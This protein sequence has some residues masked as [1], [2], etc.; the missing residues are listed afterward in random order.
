M[1]YSLCEGQTKAGPYGYSPLPLNLV[2][3]GFEQLA[4]LQGR[5]PR[6]RPRPNRDVTHVQQ[7][8]LRRREPQAATSSPRSRRSR[9]PATSRARARAA[10]TTGT[11]EPSTDDADAPTTARP[12][13]RQERRQDGGRADAAAEPGGTATAATAIDPVTGEAVTRLR[14]PAVEGVSDTAPATS[15]STPTPTELS[16]EPADATAKASAGSRSLEL[17]ALILVPGILLSRGARRR[18]RSG[19]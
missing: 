3:A 2:Q 13:R 4:K 9:P 19:R 8:D 5:R 10:P 16:A 1:Y 6:G 12:R 14:A 17:L 11:G 15:R 7:P 18:R